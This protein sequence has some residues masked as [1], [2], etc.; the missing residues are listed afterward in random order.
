MSMKGAMALITL[1][2]MFSLSK[3]NRELMNT[4]VVVCVGERDKVYVWRSCGRGGVEKGR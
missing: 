1:S 4:C 3:V 2:G